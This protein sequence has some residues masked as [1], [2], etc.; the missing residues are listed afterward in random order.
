MTRRSVDLVLG[1]GHEEIRRLAPALGEGEVRARDDGALELRQGDRAVRI[2]LGPE[3]VRA[4][5]SMRLPRTA[6]RLEFEGYDELEVAR[7]MDRFHACFRRGG[8]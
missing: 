2:G 4:L 6:V 3:G 8:G 1:F 5:G 7:F